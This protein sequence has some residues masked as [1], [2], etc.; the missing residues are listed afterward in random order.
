[1]RA[2]QAAFRGPERW[3]KTGEGVEPQRKWIGIEH[4]WQTRRE[5]LDFFAS[6]AGASNRVYQQEKKK[7]GSI[8][9]KKN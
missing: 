8:G 2:S 9:S 7:N 5:V 3:K 4:E 1:V 6:C